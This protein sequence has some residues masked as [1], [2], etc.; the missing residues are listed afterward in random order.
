MFNHVTVKN[1]IFLTSL[2]FSEEFLFLF[3]THLV[4]GI[5]ELIFEPPNG[6]LK[7][8][9]NRKTKQYLSCVMLFQL[10]AYPRHLFKITVLSVLD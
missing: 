10:M 9:V 2:A 6:Q 4:C 8:G 3:C 5:A 1:K 7:T